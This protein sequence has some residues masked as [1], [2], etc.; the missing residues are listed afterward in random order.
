M[1]TFDDNEPP[2]LDFNVAHTHTHSIKFEPQK[3]APKIKLDVSLEHKLTM[4]KQALL[5][6]IVAIPV[7]SL[8][9]LSMIFQ[10]RIIHALGEAF[11]DSRTKKGN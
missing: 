11:N 7:C 9:R 6:M 10:Y 5:M 1:K 2:R 4:D 3:E 8:L